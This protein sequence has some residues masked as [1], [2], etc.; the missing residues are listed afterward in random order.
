MDTLIDV[1][2]SLGVTVAVAESL[3]R[4]LVKISEWRDHWG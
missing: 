2:L 3:G 4:D 1:V